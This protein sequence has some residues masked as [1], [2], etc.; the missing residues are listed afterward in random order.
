M[1]PGTLI[2]GKYRLVSR[3]G[4]GA[5][6]SVWE[7]VNE[8]T[9]R[10]FAIKLIHR[11]AAGGDELRS[12]MMREARAAG[13][14]HHR[15]VIEVYDVGET[16]EGDPFLVME[17]LRGETLESLLQRKGQLSVNLTC[18][19]GVEVSRGLA[20]A[21]DAGIVHRDLK[22]A[23]IFLH[24]DPD[25][26]VV[27][28]VLDFGV[29]KVVSD[30][31]ASATTT[32]TAIGSP[33]Y[34]SP[35]QAV[36][37]PDIDARSDLWS[38]GVLLL[39]AA[40]GSPAFDG[41][42][43]YAIVG[44]ILHGELPRLSARAPNADARLDTIVARCLV[45]DRAARV[46][47]ARE[48]AAHLE[49]LLPARAEA[50]L[51]DLEEEPT[52]AREGPAEQRPGQDSVVATKAYVRPLHPES[53]DAMPAVTAGAPAAPRAMVDLPPGSATTRATLGPS[54]LPIPLIV[55]VLAMA[56]TGVIGIVLMISLST[57]SGTEPTAQPVPSVTEFP[58]KVGAP[59][60]APSA[61]LVE[62]TRPDAAPPA[63]PSASAPEIVPAPPRPTPRWP[64]PSP[65]PSGKCPSNLVYFDPASGQM[66]CRR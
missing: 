51:E 50:V 22:P 66:K 6:G 21:H 25:R 49:T 1:K 10:S 23:N 26:G 43:V 48:L 11:T 64:P 19:I 44:N 56:A 30:Q 38:V 7:A 46:A 35:E 37:A 18:A 39:E 20:A 2:A 61:T 8:L 52:L 33:A 12:R 57:T 16:A 36:G 54:N 29:S 58:P 24:R 17:L 53:S 40:S 65:K 62:P 5:M 15:N 3:L 31:N 41:D 47:T 28:K 55:G 14:L 32:G 59:A 9:Q 4:D 34:M 27:V 63:I 42:T 60:P 13:R 45:R